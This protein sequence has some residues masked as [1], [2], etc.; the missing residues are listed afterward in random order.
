[1]GQVTL[2]SLALGVATGL[3]TTL[4][5]LG[6]ALLHKRTN[7]RAKGLLRLLAILPIITPPFV[8]GLGIILLF[9]RNGVATWLA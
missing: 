6:F 5:G 9:G 7:F 8:I 4:L 2:N 3:S 1:M